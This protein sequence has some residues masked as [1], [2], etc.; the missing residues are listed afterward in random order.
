MT[1]NMTHSWRMFASIGDD[2]TCAKGMSRA[3]TQSRVGDKMRVS[4]WRMMPRFL[5]LTGALLLAVLAAGC[6]V[7]MAFFVR[8]DY[9]FAVSI[10]G[11]HD[12]YGTVPS[13]QR[14]R[15]PLGLSRYGPAHLE[16]RGPQGQVLRRVGISQNQFDRIY[17]ASKDDVAAVA[18]EVGPGH[19]SVTEVEDRNRTGENSTGRVVGLLVFALACAGSLLWLLRWFVSPVRAWKTKK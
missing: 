12:F 11:A 14:I 18:L 7:P 6:T 8:N 10:S 9:P 5:A 3:E 17:M 16:V 15:M 19:V 13:G 4:R 2:L 1:P